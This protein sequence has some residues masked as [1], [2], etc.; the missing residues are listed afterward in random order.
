MYRN[1]EKVGGQIPARV[2]LER[3]QVEHALSEIRSYDQHKPEKQLDNAEEEDNQG[4]PAC[5]GTTAPQNGCGDF[6]AESYYW[7]SFCVQAPNH[8]GD[9]SKGR[10]KDQV[11]QGEGEW[12]HLS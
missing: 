6:T 11:K 1:K 8:Q 12:Q 4:R 3:I 9:K 2:A 10:I 7:S 5:F